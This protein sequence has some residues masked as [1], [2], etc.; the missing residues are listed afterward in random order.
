MIKGKT[1]AKWAEQPVVKQERAVCPI[2]VDTEIALIKADMSTIKK[3]NE[4]SHQH[5]ER[6]IEKLDKKIDKIDNRIWAILGLLIASVLGPM[7]AN[8]F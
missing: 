4:Q 7:I 5:I 2:H 8:M 3:S 6:E 1:M